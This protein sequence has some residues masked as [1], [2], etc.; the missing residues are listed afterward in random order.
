MWSVFHRLS[1]SIMCIVLPG[2]ACGAETAASG[3]Q[4][5]RLQGVRVLLI[6]AD[7]YHEHEFWYPYYRFREEGA[8]VIVAGVEKGTVYGEGLHGKDGLPAAV[9]YPVEEIADQH[10]DLI[11]LPGGILADAASPA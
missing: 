7:G 2:M 3:Q 5:L 9:Q 4:S 10:F 1:C 8:E 11:Y 6:I